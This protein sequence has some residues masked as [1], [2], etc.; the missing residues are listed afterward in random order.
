MTPPAKRLACPRCAVELAAV[1]HGTV[2]AHHCPVCR[3]FWM[4]QEGL[5]HDIRETA[6][7]KGVQLPGVSLLEGP[8]A[9]TD[10]PCPACDQVLLQRLR[11]RGV[12]VERC[13]RCGGLFLQEGEGEL[14]TRRV[15]HA[16][17]QFGPL[18]A[19]LSAMIRERRRQG[20]QGDA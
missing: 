7:Q 2:E 4:H 5:V 19:E 8:P 1:A 14:I 3:G 9:P 17:A 20:G 18:F 6:E 13:A 11:M 12:V 10:L 16:G 15:L